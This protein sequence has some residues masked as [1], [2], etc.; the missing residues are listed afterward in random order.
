MKIAGQAFRRCRR[1]RRIDR[2]GSSTRIL[3]VDA[4][5]PRLPRL[6]SSLRPPPRWVGG[7]QRLNR[8]DERFFR[9]KSSRLLK[10][11]GGPELTMPFFVSQ[12]KFY[13]LSWT[14]WKSPGG[15]GWARLKQICRNFFDNVVHLV[16]W[17]DI[18]VTRA[19]HRGAWYL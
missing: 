15:A 3:G 10:S 19:L 6:R 9:Q 16:T 12:S 2:A 14:A 7:P 11:C 1:D 18:A 8:G 13:A 4:R 17:W 5:L